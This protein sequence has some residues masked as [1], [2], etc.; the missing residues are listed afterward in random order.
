[1]ITQFRNYGGRDSINS[2]GSLDRKALDKTYVFLF[3]LEKNI[4]WAK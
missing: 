2:V 4:S 3:R 1:M